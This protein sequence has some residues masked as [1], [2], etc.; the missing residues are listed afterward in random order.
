[1]K[2]KIYLVFISLLSVFSLKAQISDSSINVL[3]FSI[4]YSIHT[5]SADMAKRFGFSSMIGGSLDYKLKSNWSFGLDASY[6][7]GGNIKDSSSIFS[8]IMTETGYIIN[9]YGE[10]ATFS[11]SERGFYAGANISKLIPVLGP[12]KNS[13]ILINIGGGLLQHHIHIENKDNNAPPILGDYKKG[14]DK[15]SN[16]FSVKEFIGYQ[17]LDNKGVINFY[18][19]FEFYQAFT[20]SRRDYDFNLMGYD[21]TKRKDFLSGFRFGWIIPVYT[22]AP[23]KYYFY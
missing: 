18:L 5:P 19:G 15:L 10:Y 1:M 22:K 11:L 2:T 20:M 6:L 12:N 16:G 8:E 7:F 21:N 17:Y 13:G 23:D 14:Y 3:K 9:Q 4:H